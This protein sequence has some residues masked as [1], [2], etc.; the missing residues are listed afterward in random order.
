MKREKEREIEHCTTIM[1]KMC[2]IILRNITYDTI[3]FYKNVKKLFYTFAKLMM[4][5]VKG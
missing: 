2:D 5:M 1:Y 4:M 3:Y